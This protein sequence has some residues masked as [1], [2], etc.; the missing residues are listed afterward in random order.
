MALRSTRSPS[1]SAMICTVPCVAGCDG[2]MLTM[3]ESSRSGV[4]K[5]DRTG[6]ARGVST[7][8]SASVAVRHER[9]LARLRVVLAQR[10]AGEALVQQDR[11]QV[12]IAAEDDAVHVVALAL[13]E[14]RR[15]VELHE[16]VDARIGGGDARLEAHPQRLA[17][18]CEV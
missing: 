14:G 18:R 6:L 5:I 8:G 2:P 7:G 15:P 16:R 17:R 1:S 13:H 3:T 10:M 4:A 11:A 12:V 9:L